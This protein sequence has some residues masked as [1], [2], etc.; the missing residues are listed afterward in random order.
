MVVVVQCIRDHRNMRLRDFTQQ[1]YKL[2]LKGSNFFVRG[3]MTQ[4]NAG[5]SYNVAALEQL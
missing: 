2:E 3:Y 1:F 5:D 4:T